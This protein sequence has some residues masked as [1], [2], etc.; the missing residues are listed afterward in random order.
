MKLSIM[1]KEHKCFCRELFIYPGRRYIKE[2]GDSEKSFGRHSES[3]SEPHKYGKE[4]GAFQKID[5][6]VQSHGHI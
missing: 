6:N 2:I 5:Q 4:K 3:S 1:R